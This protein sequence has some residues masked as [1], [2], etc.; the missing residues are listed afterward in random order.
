GLSWPIS[1]YK[2][3]KSKSTQGKSVVFIVAI[4]IGYISGIIG[5]IINDQLTYVLIIYCF[6]LIVVSVDL[7]L[8]FINRKREKEV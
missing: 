4:I 2:S 8:F 3:I 7:V 6:N 1:V 5:K